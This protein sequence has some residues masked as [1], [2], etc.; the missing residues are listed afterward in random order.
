MSQAIRQLLLQ[1]TQE[2]LDAIADGDWP[3]YAELCAEDL[4]AFE[5]EARGQRVEGLGFHKFYFDLGVPTGTRHTT[6]IDPKVRL[7][8]EQAALVTYIRLVQSTSNSGPVTSRCEETRLWEKQDGTWRHVH[9]HRS[10][11]S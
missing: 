5:P 1:R 9:F 10:E 3:T 4:T 7:L 2:L 8:G 6:M 11:N